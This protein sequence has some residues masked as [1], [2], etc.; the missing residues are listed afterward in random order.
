MIYVSSTCS[1]KTN[2]KEAVEDLAGQGFRHIELSGGTLYYPHF[3]ED[4]VELRERHKLTYRLHNYFPPPQKSFVLN[5]ASNIES[6]LQQSRD[7]VKTAIALSARFQ[8]RQL[9][10]HAGFRISPKVEELGKQ[11]LGKTILPYED[12]LKKFIA[13]FETLATLAKAHGVELL[14]EN[15]VFSTANFQSFGGENP[16]FLTNSKE[17]FEMKKVFSFPLLLDVAHLKVSCHSLRLDF[18]REL[19]LLLP[20]SN[21]VHVSDNDG[22]SDSNNEFSKKSA[23]YQILKEHSLKGKTFTI[24]VYDGLES[25]RRCHTVL[26]SLIA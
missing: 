9:G 11:I 5:L 2:I 8:S 10:L 24:E 25:V 7:I 4:L 18:V 23:F 14:L 21:Y 19:N 12:S 22:T 16:F 20:E 6:V 17:Y 15:N 13:E 26:E 3:L 1:N